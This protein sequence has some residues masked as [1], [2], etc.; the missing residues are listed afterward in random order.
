MKVE[1][2]LQYEE[3]SARA[4][5]LG[6]QDPRDEPPAKVPERRLA[7]VLVRQQRAPRRLVRIVPVAR[8]RL[9]ARIIRARIDTSRHL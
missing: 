2:D 6:V 4:D 1:T 3:Q 5:E 7:H 8:H 9:R